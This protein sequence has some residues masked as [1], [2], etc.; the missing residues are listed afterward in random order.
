MAKWLQLNLL[1][2]AIQALGHEGLWLCYVMQQNLT[3][4]FTWIVLVW[5]E[6]KGRGQIFLCVTIWPPLLE[7]PM[8]NMT[9][10]DL[11]QMKCNYSEEG[12][13][14]RVSVISGEHF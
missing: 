14:R 11:D 5:R 1:I 7:D 8:C 4:S 12:P 13:P 3:L 2:A 6:G 10:D 9:L